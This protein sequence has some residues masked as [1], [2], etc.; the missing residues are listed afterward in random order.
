MLAPQVLVI[1][2]KKQTQGLVPLSKRLKACTCDCCSAG[3]HCGAPP[4][5]PGST[6]AAG[7]SQRGDR[8]WLAVGNKWARETIPMP[9]IGADVCRTAGNDLL[10]FKT[11]RE[12]EVNEPRT[13]LAEPCKGFLCSQS[14][15]PSFQKSTR[16]TLLPHPHT[17]DT[18]ARGCGR[19][20]HRQSFS[21]SSPLF[22][23]DGL[24]P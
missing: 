24:Q 13:D 14:F 7:G 5:S 19:G 22:T 1:C 6:A 2:S 18:L 3:E 8:W 12:T 23:L 17:S 4:G 10:G 21:P 9:S 20:S 15:F 16:V 11:N